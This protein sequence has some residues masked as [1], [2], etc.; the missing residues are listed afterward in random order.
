MTLGDRAGG[1]FSAIEPPDFVIVVAYVVGIVALGCW[2]GL[3][4]RRGDRSGRGY[5]LAGGRL[6][7]PVIGLA[8]FSTNI[9][10][11]HLVSLAQEGYVNGLAYGNFEWM[12]PFTLIALSL[13][14]APFYIRSKVATLPDFLELRYGRAC[15][16]AGI[17]VPKKV[18]DR[19]IGYIVK[20][21][22]PDGGIRYRAGMRGHSRPAITAAAVATLYSA[23]QY[24]HP[25]A[26]KA[27]VFAM[28]FLPVANTRT[29]FYYSHNYLAQALYQKGGEDWDRYYKEI[30]KHL[31]RRQAANGSGTDGRVG[32]VYNTALALV[33]LQLP[34]GYVP[35]YQR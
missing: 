2:V 4:R 25:M 13:F 33:I 9:S 31:V 24:D 3:R 1:A 8:L 23:G 6:G 29:Y 30:S 28:N 11:I 10:T 19:A 16:E 7:W 17:T 32:P 26:E 5:F 15:R 20:S 27:L 14:F 35:A 18:V 34:W 21:A 22:N 12:A